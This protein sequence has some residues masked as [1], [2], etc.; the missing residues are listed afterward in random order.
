[1]KLAKFRIVML[2]KNKVKSFQ[3]HDYV[4]EKDELVVQFKP[5][6]KY[7]H[8]SLDNKKAFANDKPIKD[9]SWGREHKKQ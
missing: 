3:A 6:G 2:T 4:R 1:M 7:V 5:K 8:F 9:G